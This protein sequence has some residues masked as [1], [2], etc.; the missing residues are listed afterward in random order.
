MIT[1]ARARSGWSRNLILL[2][3]VGV[4][5]T[6]AA[7]VAFQFYGIVHA[8]QPN[9]WLRSFV[10]GGVFL[11]LFSSTGACVLHRIWLFLSDRTAASNFDPGR[12]KLMD[13]AGTALAAAPFAICGYG[14]LIQRTDFHI[15]EVEVPISN[16]PPDL[17][18]LRILQ[19]SDI[20]IGPFLTE[21]DL[22]RVIDES[23]NLR[24]HL[25][26]ITGD[27]ISMRGDPL[28]ACL[29][30][31]ARLRPD[32]G[33]L[34]CMGNHEAYAE[35]EAYTAEQGGRLGIDFLRSRARP[36]KFGNATLNVAGMDYQ[37][38]SKRATYL[39]GAERL[40][41][42]DAV[43]LLLAHNPDV[44]PVAAKKAGRRANGM[45]LYVIIDASAR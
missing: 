11:W 28:D 19:L 41:A 3:L 30:Q 6:L 1:V 38:V 34:G 18:G 7:G 43:N 37:S 13:A 14:A 8:L 12:R 2:S 36:L 17:R 31:I 25:A 44:F 27:L 33:I 10:G 24:P 45:G 5:A 4:G 22:A 16:L 42:P 15:R 21:R 39:T 23:L 20:H 29:R 26:V 9:P 32:A 35:T 40:V